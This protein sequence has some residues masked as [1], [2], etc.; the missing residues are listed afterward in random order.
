MTKMH[1]NELEITEPLVRSLLQSQ[2]LTWAHLP[3]KPIESSGTDHA[4]FRLGDAYVALAE[5]CALF[6]NTL[7]KINFANA[8]VYF[9]YS[10]NMQRNFMRQYLYQHWADS[11]LILALGIMAV[12]LSFL[13]TTPW[14][15][16]LI[17]LQFPVYLIHEFEEHVFPG[18]F[19]QFINREV[20][21]STSDNAPLSVPAVFWINILAIWVLFPIAAILAQNVSP[22]FGLL[23][24]I[25]GLFNATLHIVMFIVK[26]KYNPGLIVSA[27][28][29]YPT[30][31]YTLYVLAQQNIIHRLSLSMAL[32]VTV[33]AHALIIVCVLKNKKFR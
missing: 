13:P 17:W 32:L 10:F 5:D 14:Y 33:F 1:L 3:L 18:H 27:C 23:L 2:C 29:N 4:L 11:T 12:L 20:F 15:L 8:I 21:H 31:I 16:F 19:R 6:L 28:L 24:P 25:F 7:H 30:G 9:S 22:A 26:R